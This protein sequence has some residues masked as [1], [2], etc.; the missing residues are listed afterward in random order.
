MTNHALCCDCIECTP[1]W[2]AKSTT[3]RTVRYT[4]ASWN[5]AIRAPLW[6][7]ALRIRRRKTFDK[8]RKVRHA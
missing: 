8:L 5:V 4:I 3:V 7:R 2:P 6:K 1:G